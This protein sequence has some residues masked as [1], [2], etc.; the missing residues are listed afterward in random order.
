MRH[1]LQRLGGERNMSFG[2]DTSEQGIETR[3]DTDWS[4]MVDSHDGRSPGRVPR[5]NRGK[6]RDN[7][8]LQPGIM[9]DRGELQPG[10][11]RHA[12]D[13]RITARQARFEIVRARPLKPSFRVCRKTGRKLN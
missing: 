4:V 8:H 3:L 10:P 11:V 1:S 5:V 13:G 6:N 9:R 7:G 12:D 2:W